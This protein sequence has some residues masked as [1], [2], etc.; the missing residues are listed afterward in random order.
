MRRIAE[1]GKDGKLVHT[2]AAALIVG[3]VLRHLATIVLLLA[4]P[5]SLRIR[6]QQQH[7]AV[8]RPD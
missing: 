5:A 2:A 7:T 4:V 1:T 3:V 6:Q 8:C